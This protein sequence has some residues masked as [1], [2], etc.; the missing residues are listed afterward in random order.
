MKRMFVAIIENGD[1]FYR[2]WDGYIP[3]EHAKKF[4]LAFNNEFALNLMNSLNGA[5]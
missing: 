3:G 4:L 2:Q 1:E 5:P